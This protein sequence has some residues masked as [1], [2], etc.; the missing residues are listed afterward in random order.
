ME[1]NMKDIRTKAVIGAIVVGAMI[2]GTGA[3]AAQ[4]AEPPLLVAQTASTSSVPALSALTPRSASTPSGS[5]HGTSSPT[6]DESTNGI[7]IGP[8][9]NWVK[10]NAPSILAPMKNAVKN[11]LTSFKKWWN[12]LASWIKSGINFIV[13]CSLTEL[14]HALWNYF[15]G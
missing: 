15:F 8:L 3:G 12:G 6:Q 7:P 10:A 9:I 4:A 13:N 1:R 14:F 11:G 5:T 2:G